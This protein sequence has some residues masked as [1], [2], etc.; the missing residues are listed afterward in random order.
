MVKATL[1]S[2]FPLSLAEVVDPLESMLPPELSILRNTDPREHTRP[3]LPFLFPPMVDQNPSF[4]FP[5]TL[6]EQ[7]W[8]L[9]GPEEHRGALS[10]ILSV[11]C[12]E[13]RMVV[14]IDKESLQVTTQKK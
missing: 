13:S 14:S 8:S 5:P 3:N 10:G 9:Q 1:T 7:E 2:E 12:E 11:Q 4:S 6:E